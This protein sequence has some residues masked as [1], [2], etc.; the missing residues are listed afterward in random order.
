MSYYY[1]PFQEELQREVK[2][3]ALTP[4]RQGLRQ[5]FLVYANP[6]TLGLLAGGTFLAYT[7]FAQP[8]PPA[9]TPTPG[10]LPFLQVG[11]TGGGMIV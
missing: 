6:I 1:S 10:V 11:A 2:R 5:G 8:G 3:V 7:P 4:K 9:E